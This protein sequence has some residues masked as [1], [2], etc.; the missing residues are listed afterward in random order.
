MELRNAARRKDN[1]VDHSIPPDAL[2]SD[3]LYCIKEYVRI[4]RHR[5]ILR[6]HWFRGLTFEELAEKNEV[7][8]TAIKHVI[9]D[10]G[11]DILVRAVERGAERE[12]KEKAI[13][14]T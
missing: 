3:I 8:T 12:A 11:D 13:N 6:D 9:Y 2:N 5:Q 10:I 4:V 1:K 14:N 7:T